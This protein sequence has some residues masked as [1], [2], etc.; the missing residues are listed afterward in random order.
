M[1]GGP[2]LDDAAWN[3]PWRKRATGDKVLL[4]GGLLLCGVGLPAWPVAPLVTIVCLALLLGPAR[5]PARVPIR[6]ALGL[7]SFL[8]LG[9]ITLALAEDPGPDTPGVY[10]RWAGFAVTHVTLMSAAQTTAHS[11][12]GTSAMVLLAATTPM[13]SLLRWAGR[14]GV[15]AVVVEIAD[16]IYRFIFLLLDTVRAVH[17]AQ[18][19]RLGYTTRRA[20]L[21][22]S[23]QLA[24]VVLVRAWSRAHRL[25]DGLDGRGYQG[26]IAVLDESGERST[27]FVTGSILLISTLLAI[28]LLSL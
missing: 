8:V 21:R 10:W 9:A 14:R 20:M 7:S 1:S 4:G 26:T 3:S 6:V 16:L 18:A 25:Q 28:G 15:P 5:V 12:A 13:S 22:S 23:S 17:E 27:A 11:I 24:A 2:L 19:A